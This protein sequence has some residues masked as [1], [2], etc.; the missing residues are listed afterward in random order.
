MNKIDLM[1][2]RNFA[3]QMVE[4]NQRIN[5][6]K[7]AWGLNETT[8]HARKKFEI[9]SELK[10]LGKEF[11]TEVRFRNGGRA[12]IFVLDEP[13]ALEILNSETEKSI[14]NK[15]NKYPCRIVTIGINEVF[16]EEMLY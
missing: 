4:L 14:L 11:V 15:K 13:L 12:D 3:L 5:R 1:S 9:C 8:E 2:Q 7:L 6:N 10:K 16:K